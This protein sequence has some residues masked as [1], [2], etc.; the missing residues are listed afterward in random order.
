MRTRRWIAL[1]LSL[2]LAL[3][4][5]CQALGR[6]R[7]HT[8]VVEGIVQAGDTYRVEPLDVDLEN[9]RGPGIPAEVRVENVDGE[10]IATTCDEYGRF[11]VG[12][13]G[14]GGRDE[15][16][17]T[18]VCPGTRALCLSALLPPEVHAAPDGETVVVRWRITLPRRVVGEAGA[19]G[20]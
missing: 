1:V 13:I 6:G 9:W 15:D 10:R 16:R 7:V 2:P 8:V 14:V 19:G 12:P 11:R 3:L 17:L 18:V 5:G 4:A 20:H